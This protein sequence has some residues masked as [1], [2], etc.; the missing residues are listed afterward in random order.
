MGFKQGAEF[1][2]E[3]IKNDYILQ[4]LPRWKERLKIT[5]LSERESFIYCFKSRQDFR[6]LIRYR[7]KRYDSLELS[8]GFQQITRSSNSFVPALYL[9]CKNIGPGFYIEHGFSSILF[10]SSIG[11]NFHLNQCV[12]IGSGKGGV[13]TIGNDVSVFCNSVIIG[14]I[15]IGDNVKIAAGSTVVDNVPDNCTVASPK[16]VIIKRNGSEVLF[17]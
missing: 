6:S 15:N 11:D 10:A 1:F 7:V 13:P 2:Y 3:M 17:P 16:A 4:D 12:T 9:S 5:E 14:N 8:R